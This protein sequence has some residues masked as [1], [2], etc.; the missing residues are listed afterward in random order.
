[1]SIQRAPA[2]QGAAYWQKYIKKCGYRVAGFVQVIRE[3][4]R[5][6]MTVPVPAPVAASPESQ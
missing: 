2:T 3:R 4:Y 5:H 6:H 1:M